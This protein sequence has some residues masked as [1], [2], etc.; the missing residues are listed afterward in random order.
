M[1]A[2]VDGILN[3]SAIASVPYEMP[4]SLQKPEIDPQIYIYPGG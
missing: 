1:S 3:S 2:N 4:S